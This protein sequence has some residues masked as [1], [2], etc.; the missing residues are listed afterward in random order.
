MTVDASPKK[1]RESTWE[2]HIKD[3]ERRTLPL[4]AEVVKL[5]VE[6]QMSQ[7]EGNP[8][9]FVPMARYER[10]QGLG[11]QTPEDFALCISNAHRE[12]LSDEEFCPHYRR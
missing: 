2:W 4:T 3:T 7:P 12:L 11:V 8:Y 5:L 10:I 1:D 6:R 9:I